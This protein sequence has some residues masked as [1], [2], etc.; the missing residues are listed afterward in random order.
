M[1]SLLVL[2]AVAADRPNVLLVITDDQSAPHASAYA[3]SGDIAGAVPKSA[4]HTPGFDRIAA[5]GHL[6]THCYAASPGCAPSRAGLLTGRH[7]WMLEQAGTHA[8][9]FPAK[10]PTYPDLLEDAGY[11]V[12]FTGKPWGPG[13]FRK[14]GRDR[15]PAGVDFNRHRLKPPAKGISNKDYA[16]NFETFLNERDDGQP[17]CFWYGAQEPH[18]PFADGYGRSLGKDPA[19]AVVPPFLPDTPTV[20]S[21]LLDYY[22]EIE[23]ADAHLVRMLDELDRRGELA[24]TLVIVTSDNGMAFPRAKANCYEYGF[25]VPLAV[26]WPARWTDGGQRHDEVVGFVDL[27]ATILEAAG[28]RDPQTPNP[29]TGRSLIAALGGD[30]D[31]WPGV[32]FASRERHSSS[33]HK[34]GTYPQ[35]AIRQGDH[36]YI[37]NDRPARWPAG[38]PQKFDG[39]T[40]GPPHGGYH[41]IDACPTLT[42]LI[43]RRSEFNDLFRLAVDK[44]PREELF[45]V[46]AD[47]GCVA[48]LIGPT[49]KPGPEVVAVL[50]ELA[51]RL[52]D[53]RERTGDPRVTGDGDIWETYPRYSAIRRFPKP[54]KTLP[55]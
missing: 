28:V 32:A 15:N 3:A 26:A 5:A 43:D 46:A 4:L 6:F 38:D 8:S 36:L 42:E 2:A 10:F 7:P 12:G 16:R 18:R 19:D 29:T 27:T 45:N 41:D 23:Y 37:V 20:R 49:V 47:P 44:R 13:D 17:F 51:E 52:E 34:N 39:E 9:S 11:F 22:A 35:R 54:P 30:A 31:A 55:E 40:L 53:E 33:R 1:L 25:N 21:D 24:D 50:S 48:P 14:G